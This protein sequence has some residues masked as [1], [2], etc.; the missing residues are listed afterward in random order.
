L[1]NF[2]LPANLPENG[3]AVIFPMLNILGATCGGDPLRRSVPAPNRELTRFKL[4]QISELLLP[5][6]PVRPNLSIWQ[7]NT[8]TVSLRRP[9]HGREAHNF[10]ERRDRKRFLAT[11]TA[12]LSF[13]APQ[14]R[15]FVPWDVANVILDVCFS[16]H[17][18]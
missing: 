14:R 6:I 16:R 3:Q 5:K 15:Q 17:L 4:Y 1:A 18:V 2:R 13:T 7:H 9:H 11:R 8:E 10:A 12:L